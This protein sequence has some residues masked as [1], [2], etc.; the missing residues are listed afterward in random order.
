MKQRWKRWLAA[1]VSGVMLC[2]IG[3]VM[4][5]AAP[6]MSAQMTAEA[7]GATLEDEIAI[8]LM[9]I[10]IRPVRI[11][12]LIPAVIPAHADAIRL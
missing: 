6:E 1:A 2:M 9:D 5:G 12:G 10:R 3:G 11:T 8:I 7:A 4:P